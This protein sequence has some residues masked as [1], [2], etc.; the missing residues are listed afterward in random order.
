MQ[1]WNLLHAARWKC[2]THKSR[3][4]S[5]SEH[6]RT[7]LSSYIFATKAYIDN[8]KK[9]LLSSNMSSKC[10]HNIVNF[11]PLVAEIGLPV[12][13]T[14][15]KFQRLLRLGSVTARQSSS[16][17][18]PNFAALNRGRYL[19]LAGRP[20]RWPLAHILVHSFILQRTRKNQRNKSWQTFLIFSSLYPSQPTDVVYAGHPHLITSAS[21]A[22]KY[23]LIR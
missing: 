4:K 17:R 18:Q 14:P 19:C 13:G 3:Q 20:S 22:I 1:V 11:G 7:T 8:R 16:G 23:K 12:C 2:R 5:P 10:P 15:S 21:E 9:N 6:H